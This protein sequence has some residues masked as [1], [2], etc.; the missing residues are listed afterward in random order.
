MTI[1]R[2][3]YGFRNFENYVES[4]YYVSDWS[5]IGVAPPSLAQSRRSAAQETNVGNWR[6]TVDAFRTFLAAVGSDE[7]LS[8]SIKH[9]LIQQLGRN[10]ERRKPASL[11]RQDASRTPSVGRQRESDQRQVSNPQPPLTESKPLNHKR[12]QPH[13]E[14]R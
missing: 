2:Q 4:R 13:T 9:L 3:A 12:S 8:N 10:P 6:A 7:Q 1:T 5:G 14:S 11:S